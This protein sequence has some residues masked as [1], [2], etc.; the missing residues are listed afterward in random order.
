M[1][2]LTCLL[3]G[4][5]MLAVSSVVSAEVARVSITARTPVAGGQAFGAV[6]AYE[7]LTGTIEFAL[8]P[9]DPHNQ[10][11]TDLSLAPKAADGR[12]HFGADLIVLQPTDTTK[13]NG[14]LLFEV[15]NRGRIGVL[16]KFNSAPRADTSPAADVGNG[17]LMRQGYTLVF[18]G[19]EFDLPPGTIRLE[20]PAIDGL[21]QAITVPFILDRPSPVDPEGRPSDR[22]GTPRH[23]PQQG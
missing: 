12:V 20:A 11:V 23:R 21:R 1:R 18:V 14:V 8:D 16:E 7:S 9:R 17:Y 6:G 3:A 4:L 2:A 15:V 10:L 5:A 22:V 13:G 19:W